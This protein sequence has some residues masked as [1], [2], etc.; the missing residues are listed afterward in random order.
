MRCKAKA[1]EPF[2]LGDFPVCLKQA[3]PSLTTADW[4][5]AKRCE[6][7]THALTLQLEG[8]YQRCAWLLSLK[9]H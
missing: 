6:E 1:E 2:R 8:T 7:V 4:A 5:Q 9:E 3:S